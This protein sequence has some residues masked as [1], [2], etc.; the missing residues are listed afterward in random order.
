MQK[1]VEA[2]IAEFEAKQRKGAITVI[3]VDQLSPE[4]LLDTIRP[5][6]EV[7]MY[8]ANRRPI[9]ESE[10]DPLMAHFTN[11]HAYLGELLGIMAHRVRH[12]ELMGRK[13]EGKTARTKRE[14]LEDTRKDVKMHWETIKTLQFAQGQS[15]RQ[16][17]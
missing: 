14:M 16:I 7:P 8:G 3:N 6:V 17:D 13:D 9:K 10:L 2:L 4:H 5:L 15:L 12:Y 11:Y 1:L